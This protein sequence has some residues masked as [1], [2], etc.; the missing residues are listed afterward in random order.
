MWLVCEA[1]LVLSG[2]SEVRSRAK[3]REVAVIDQ[4]S[5]LG[6]D[7]YRGCHLASFPGC[8]GGCGSEFYVLFIAWPY[9]IYIFNL[10]KI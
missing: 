10:S 2:W 4:G 9:L 6:A 8:L 3:I 7:C 5:S 1:C